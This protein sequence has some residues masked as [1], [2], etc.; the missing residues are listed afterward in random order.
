MSK[1]GII[2]SRLH[3]WSRL[4]CI[5]CSTPSGRSRIRQVDQKKKHGFVAPALTGVPT[6]IDALAVGVGVAFVNTPIMLVALV[7]GLCTFT[8][9]TIGVMLGRALGAVVGKRAEVLGGIILIGVGA[10]ILYEHL[11]T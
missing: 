5:W 1:P 3:C 2:G 7:I 6:S 11:S 8:M 9:V 10:I 4:V